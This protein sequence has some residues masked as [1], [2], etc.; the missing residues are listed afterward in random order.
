MDCKA[1]CLKP[2]N[3]TDPNDKKR[4]NLC[5]GLNTLIKDVLK[6]VGIKD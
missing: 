6:V 2:L 5:S 4:W 1:I 3:K